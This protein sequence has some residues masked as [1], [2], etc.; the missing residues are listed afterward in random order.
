MGKV[1]G[2]NYSLA[3]ENPLRQSSQTLQVNY[4]PTTIRKLIE[5]TRSLMGDVKFSQYNPA[6][7]N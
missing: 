7:N 3:Q 1:I 4:K 5:D 6:T 2:I